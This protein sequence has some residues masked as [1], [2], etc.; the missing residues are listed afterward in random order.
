MKLVTKAVV[1]W[2]DSVF[3]YAPEVFTFE[4][5]GEHFLSLA[6]EAFTRYACY[7]YVNENMMGLEVPEEMSLDLYLYFEDGKLFTKMHQMLIYPNR[8][9]TDWE[10][11]LE[12]EKNRA[13]CELTLWLCDALKDKDLSESLYPHHGVYRVLET[14]EVCAE[15]NGPFDCS[16][17]CPYY[18]SCNE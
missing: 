13:E 16:M 18:W 11:L 5:H 6:T 8:F 7:H 9:K 17:S 15:N 12:R 10:I 4:T 3:D 14:D 1:V 2:N